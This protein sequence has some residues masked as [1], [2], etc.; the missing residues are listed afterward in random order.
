MSKIKKEDLD[1][2]EKELLQRRKDNKKYQYIGYL[3]VIIIGILA[4]VIPLM[5]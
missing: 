4:I 1:N 3:L 2:L 5:I